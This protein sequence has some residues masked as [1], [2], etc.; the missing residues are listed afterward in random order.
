MTADG[1]GDAVPDLTVLVNTVDHYADCWEPFFTLFTRFWPDCGLPVLLNT[2]HRD[3]SWPGLDVT[4]VR[5]STG[6]PDGRE[7][8]W[9]RRF[10]T[11]LQA[12]ATPWVLYLED[13]MFLDA[14]VKVALVERFR[15][16]AE[17]EDLACVRLAE[18]DAD[19]TYLP[20]PYEG[21]WEVGPSSPYLMSGHA[22]IWRVETLVS[23]VRA[24]ENPWQYEV[25]GGGRIRRRRLPIH[26]V[27][28]DRFWSDPATRIVPYDPDT[29][30]VK[31]RWR[32][33]LV[34][35]LFAAHG[36]ALDPQPRGWYD[37]AHPHSPFP[38][39]P[40]PLRALARLR[41]L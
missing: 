16:L 18:P 10:L 23:L 39:K 25:W 9:G 20:S 2:T 3:W 30:I 41:S 33:D 32:R 36:I 35:P 12:V 19:A 11:G 15:A 38:R 21:L 37:P 31:G 7:L 5:N 24:H 8:P 29:G 40:L 26:V 4:A 13:D 6:I 27:D 34:E 22:A 14:P 17:A 1:S 28:R